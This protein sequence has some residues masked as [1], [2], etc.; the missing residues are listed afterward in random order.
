MTSLKPCA[1]YCTV[2]SGMRSLPSGA[3]SLKTTGLADPAPIMQTLMSDRLRFSRYRLDNVLATVD[4]ATGFATLERQAESVKQVAVADNLLMT[5][6]DLTDAETARSPS[7]R[8]LD[9][10]PGVEIINVVHGEVDPA[11]IFGQ[12][13]EHSDG[14]SH[15]N[16]RW[17]DTMRAAMSEWPDRPNR[18]AVV[19]AGHD[20]DASLGSHVHTGDVGTFHLTRQRAV[21]WDSFSGWLEGLIAIH[22]E[23]I[24]RIKGL[25]NVA[26]VDRPVVIHGV[27]HIFHPP[28]RLEPWPD[29]DRQSHIVVI[30]R[31][32]DG[33]ALANEFSRFADG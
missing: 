27:Q 4:A 10:N 2:K 5:K 13:S 30:A 7:F 15:N 17:L 1:P 8:L 12:E 19:A 16:R 14:G 21:D 20:G 29:R 25:L 32:L 33:A 31:G 23:Q 26:G 9:L 18:R 11:Q 22:G 24:L 3:S 28:V 6:T